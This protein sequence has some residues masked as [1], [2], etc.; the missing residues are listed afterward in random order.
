MIQR[1]YEGEG[2]VLRGARDERLAELKRIVG[3]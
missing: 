2:D 1:A 3:Y